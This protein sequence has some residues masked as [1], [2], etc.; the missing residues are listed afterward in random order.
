M[1]IEV[2]IEEFAIILKCISDKVEM[3]IERH[4]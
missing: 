2:T 1:N 3:E 4:M